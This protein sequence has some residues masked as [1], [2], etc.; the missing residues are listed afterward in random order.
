MIVGVEPGD[1]V[2]EA[3]CLADGGARFGE[4]GQFE[5]V[6]PSS[7]VVEVHRLGDE[8]AA[9]DADT[10]RQ[11]STWVATFRNA[12]AISSRSCASQSGETSM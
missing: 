8:S 3:E 2:A 6:T 4:G 9:D 11:A 7:E 10:E 5:K 12:S 1:A